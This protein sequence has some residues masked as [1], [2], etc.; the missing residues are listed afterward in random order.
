MQKG[1]AK[2]M[3]FFLLCK[4]L[5]LI[6]RVVGLHKKSASLNAMRDVQLAIT[7]ANIDGFIPGI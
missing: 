5:W 6:Y 7:P 3:L 2:V 1:A 4:C